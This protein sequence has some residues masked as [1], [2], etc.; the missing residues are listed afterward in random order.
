MVNKAI[1][2]IIIACKSLN[3]NIQRILQCG[4][5]QDIQ[6]AMIVCISYSFNWEWAVFDRKDGSN[7]TID[8]DLF[9][10]LVL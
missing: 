8:F 1:I 6:K 2:S 7:F 5:Q 4:G 3:V 9:N 10:L